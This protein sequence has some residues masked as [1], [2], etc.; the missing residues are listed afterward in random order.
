MY[1]IIQLKH[2]K[3]KPKINDISLHLLCEY[4]EAFL[5]PFIYQYEIEFANHTKKKLKLK[6]ELENFCHLLGLE[7]VA[8][9]SVKSAERFQYKG[10]T[11]CSHCRNKVWDYFPKE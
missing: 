9:N 1:N 8:K 3:S 6:F 5:N 10:K 2:L 4:Y 11:G 7:S